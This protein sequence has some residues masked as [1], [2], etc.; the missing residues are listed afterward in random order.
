MIDFSKD[1]HYFAASALGWN[2]GTKLDQVIRIRKKEDRRKG[3]I[4]TNAFAVWHVPL[5][6]K[7]HYGISG[8]SPD[9]DG[10]VQIV[11]EHYGDK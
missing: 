10:A 1:H 8:S 6:V 11:Y 3:T 2:T 5:N 4:Q 7:E 9:V